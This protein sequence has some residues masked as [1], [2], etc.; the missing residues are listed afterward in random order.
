MIRRRLLPLALLLI[1]LVGALYVAAHDYVE[2]T[3]FVIRAAGMQGVPR[4]LAL[5]EADRLEEHQT[6]IA[7]RGGELRARTYVPADIDRRAIL[8]VPG[9]HAGGIDEPRLVNFAREIAATGHPVITAELP[10]LVAYRITPRTTDMIQDAALWIRREWRAA[11]PSGEDRVGLMGISFAGGLAVVAASRLP[12]DVAWALSFGG[13]GD[14]PRTLRYLC[15]GVEPDGARRPPHDYGVVI[16]LL[17]VVDRLVPSEQVEPVQNGIRAFL[18]ASHVDMVDKTKGAL[19][20]ARARQ[21][22]DHLA[23]PGRTY[24]RWVNDRNV[25]ELGAALLPHVSAMGGDTALS[26]ERNPPPSVPVYLLHG[27]DDNVVPAAESALLAADLRRRGGRVL[28][29]AT[30]LITHA[31]V[32][33]PPGLREIWRLIRFWAAPL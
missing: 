31:E 28:Q 11:V 6:T 26:P 23:E 1:V 3:A 7:W 4:K 17:G 13:H 22:A 20:F 10:D 25:A 9:V 30:P 12:D 2:A 18:H 32:D 33:R 5:L 15:T 19:E 27:A 8:L 16:I 29:L 21:L 14:L 24:L